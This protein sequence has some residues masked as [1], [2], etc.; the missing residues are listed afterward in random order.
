MKHSLTEG[1]IIL[2]LVIFFWGIGAR[3]MGWDA[4]GNMLIVAGAALFGYNYYKRFMKK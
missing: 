2:S 3:M 1:L 4:K